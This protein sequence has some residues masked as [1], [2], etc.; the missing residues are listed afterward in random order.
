LIAH[1]F[2][3]IGLVVAVGIGLAYFRDIG[4]VSQMIMRV[5][6]KNMVRFIRNEYRLLAVG[7][8]ATA[9]IFPS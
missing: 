2:F 6:R 4:D 7:L 8:G 5:K 1:F 3:F 9:L